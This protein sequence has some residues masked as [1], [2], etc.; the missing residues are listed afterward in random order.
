MFFEVAVFVSPPG[1]QFLSFTFEV[2]QISR[3]ALGCLNFFFWVKFSEIQSGSVPFFRKLWTLKL[4]C[5]R[6]CSPLSVF[7]HVSARSPAVSVAR[8]SAL[9]TRCLVPGFP[10][11]L[12]P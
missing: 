2:L 9:S 5:R 12:V 8:F 10:L 6:A 11:L 4:K 3:E 1:F 7:F